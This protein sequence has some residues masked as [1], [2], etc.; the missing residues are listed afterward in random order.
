M[1]LILRGYNDQENIS[2]FSKCMQRVSKVSTSCRD[3]IFAPL[4]GAFRFQR[5][6]LVIPQY[7]ILRA[8]L[9]FSRTTS[10]RQGFHMQLQSHAV[11]LW[12]EN[13]SA[14]LWESFIQNRESALCGTGVN[15]TAF[16]W[17][18]RKLGAI[19][20]VFACP[21][22]RTVCTFDGF[23]RSRWNDGV[24]SDAMFCNERRSK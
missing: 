22:L 23:R 2:M 18:A 5:I 12:S 11:P 20:K 24:S 8:L 17:T 19:Q 4:D 1:S 16:D 14:V 13:I 9:L 3:R 15:M 6:F 7:L 10:S 21:A